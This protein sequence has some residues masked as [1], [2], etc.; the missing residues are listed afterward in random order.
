MESSRRL[1]LL[2]IPILA[3]SLLL[4]RACKSGTNLSEEEQTSLIHHVDSLSQTVQSAWA[5]LLQA[6]DQFHFNL[7]SFVESLAQSEGISSAQ[8]DS[9]IA[10]I[11]ALGPLRRQME[12]MNSQAIDNYDQSLFALGEAILSQ[13][14]GTEDTS[15]GGIA[16]A[17]GNF[18]DIGLLQLRN[19]YDDAA[20]VYNHWFETNGAALPKDIEYTNKYPLFALSE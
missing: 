7:R 19:A 5:T 10:K 8:R 17:L 6:D 2:L 18:M 12:G 14:N 1:S 16:L 13:H 11:E 15:T 9:L 20:I 3:F 4:F